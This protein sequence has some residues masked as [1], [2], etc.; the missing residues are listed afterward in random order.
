MNYKPGLEAELVLLGILRYLRDLAVEVEGESE[1][2][3]GCSGA[4]VLRRAANE[5]QREL[6]APHPVEPM[7]YL[8]L[9]RY[10]R[11][12]RTNAEREISGR[13]PL[14]ATAAGQKEQGRLMNQA[15]TLE[16]ELDA[17]RRR[18]EALERAPRAGYATVAKEASE[19]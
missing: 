6:Q 19:S 1:A 2:C 17:M 14:W 4:G 11:N 10:M 7:D 16:L 12:L 18:V 9:Q 3:S 13:D 5:L 15:A 8:E